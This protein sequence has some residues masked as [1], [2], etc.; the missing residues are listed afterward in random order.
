MT[1]KKE[2]F[3]KK[4]IAP[5][6]NKIEEVEENIESLNA[7]KGSLLDRKYEIARQKICDLLEIDKK[8]L[9]FVCELLKVK[10]EEQ[11][12]QNAVEKL[13]R[14]FGLSLIVKEKYY[15]KTSDFINKNTFADT[16]VR[17]YKVAENENAGQPETDNQTQYIFDKVEIKPEINT[18]FKTWI[19]NQL[20][21]QFDYECC[22]DIVC[23]QKAKKAITA[24]GLVKR[25][26]YFHEKD[27]TGRIKSGNYILGWDN[28]EKILALQNELTE[29]Q[30][31]LKKKNI[32]KENISKEI[33]NF[34]DKQTAVKELLKIETFP[35]IDF[36]SLKK[37]IAK[38][39]EQLTELKENP[40]LEKLKATSIELEQEIKRLEEEKLKLVEAISSLKTKIEA[41]AESIKECQTEIET[42]TRTE[43]EAFYP[44]IPPLISS[45]ITHSNQVSGMKHL[46][47]VNLTGRKNEITKP[48]EDLK[49]EIEDA[50]L[51]FKHQFP[52][53]MKKEEL[54]NEI[55]FLD[56]F[57][58]FYERLENENLSELK[59]KFDEKLK[60]R[61]DRVIQDFW[62]ILD[63]QKNSI[64]NKTGNNGRI[65]E[66][67]KKRHYQ[68]NK[69]YLQ[70]IP[71]ES[72]DEEIIN[73]K[74]EV[75]SCFYPIGGNYTAEEKLQRNK[76]IFKNIK[77]LL[78][79]LEKYDLPGE[80]WANKVTDVRNWFYF[81][82]S[83]KD[84]NNAEI[85]IKAHSGTAS[86]SGGETFKITYTILAAAIADEFGL[87]G[88][89]ARTNSLRFIAVDEIFNNLGVQWSTYVLK[90]FEDMDLQLLIVSPD[91]LEKA[92]IAKDHIKN[93]H[94]TYK[95]SIDQNNRTVDNSYVVDIKFEELTQKVN[96]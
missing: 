11:Q 88:N 44:L 8:Q 95:K 72:K 15:K 61:S 65:N 54:R 31:T 38:L 70:I 79:K 67:L 14:S 64:E 73:F 42:A 17:F 62:M 26:K 89:Q 56:E 93:V 7:N 36:H 81:T 77:S 78:E 5:L 91:S 40:D 84:I 35:D 1:T 33:K 96:G 69:S 57:T 48:A 6:E 43:Q 13:L 75:K 39:K 18:V 20:H 46:I 51:S 82:A 25:N 24:N 59:D 58:A 68:E 9:P 76:R 22:N 16:K 90:M 92:N 52:D 30:K 50:M 23:L 3:L 66:L 63:R 41:D 83:E 85:E 47:N 87:V 21:Q 45:P 34:E 19:E 2:N 37:E 55:T 86:K 10:P 53:D 60:R 12:W 29:L 74:K 28:T 27:D 94:W 71:H 4:E 32:E 49:K 80:R